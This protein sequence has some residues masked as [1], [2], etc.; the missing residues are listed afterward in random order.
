LSSTVVVS[1]ASH[2]GFSVIA[3]AYRNL[4]LIG[5]LVIMLFIG[6][7]LQILDGWPAVGKRMALTG[8]ILFPLMMHIR[9]PI[10][11]LPAQVIMGL[12]I[13]KTYTL[14]Y[15][16]LARTRRT[17]ATSSPKRLLMHNAS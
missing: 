2:I 11:P 7:I 1:R 17:S 12:V 6:L 14:L 10:S 13:L 15:K 3:E 8:I 5:V 9:N 16:S 4:G